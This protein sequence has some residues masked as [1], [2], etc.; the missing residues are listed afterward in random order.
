MSRFRSAVH[1]VVSIQVAQ[2]EAAGVPLLGVDIGLS[3][4]LGEA[5][6]NAGRVTTTLRRALEE[7][8]ASSIVQESKSCGALSV[9]KS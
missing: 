2:I 5:L 8:V 9:G 4:H 6:V 1:L 3:A 7:E